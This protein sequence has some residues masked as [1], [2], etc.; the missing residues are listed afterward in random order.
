MNAISSL[1][2]FLFL[3]VLSACAGLQNQPCTEY[4]QSKKNAEA[5]VSLANKLKVEGKINDQE[6][7]RIDQDAGLYSKRIRDLCSFLQTKKIT[8]PEYEDG[9]QKA[10]EDYQ[11][12]RQLVLEKQKKS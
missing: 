10:S 12:L 6:L 1:P 2:S 4:D 7:I 11:K 3:L 9:I 8:Y 5:V